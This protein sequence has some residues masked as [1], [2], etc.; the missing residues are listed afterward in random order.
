M[1]MVLTV[2]KWQMLVVSCRDGAAEEG[3]S[4]RVLMGPRDVLV[5]VPR[6]TA[7]SNSIVGGSA[8]STLQ[9]VSHIEWRRSVVNPRKVE[10][11]ARKYYG[12][13]RKM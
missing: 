3:Q 8:A 7:P 12:C 5:L 13:F 2:Q 9:K 1:C 10:Q 6:A 11:G 4:V